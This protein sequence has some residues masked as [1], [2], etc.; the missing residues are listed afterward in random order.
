MRIFISWVA[1]HR[2]FLYVRYRNAVSS[3]RT[4]DILAKWPHTTLSRNHVWMKHA[5]RPC[6]CIDL[7]NVV[8]PKEYKMQR[9]EGRGEAMHRASEW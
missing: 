7:V 6:V 5:M 8:W 4:E 2:L 1:R 9:A 3:D